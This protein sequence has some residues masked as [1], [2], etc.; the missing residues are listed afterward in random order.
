MVYVKQDE[1]SSKT[2]ECLETC[3]K[4][5]YPFP[6]P[7]NWAWKEHKSGYEDNLKTDRIV[8]H[9]EP[10]D[11]SGIHIKLEVYDAGDRRNRNHS[12]WSVFIEQGDMLLSHSNYINGNL[13]DAKTT[14]EQVVVELWDFKQKQ[15]NRQRKI[16]YI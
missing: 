8:A 15:L 2:K 16:L 1:S 10:F 7:G 11:N 9:Y 3:E 5:T 14:A 4:S 13:D 12:G 6:A